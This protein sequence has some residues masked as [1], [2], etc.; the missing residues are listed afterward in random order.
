MTRIWRFSV[1]LLLSLLLSACGG[2]KAP[3][4]TVSSITNTEQQLSL[5][6]AGKPI[7]MTFWA[8][9]C[10]SCL[11][12]IPYLSAM[13][14]EFGER[15]AVIGVAMSYDDPKQ[16]TTFIQQRQIPYMITHDVD[17]SVSKGFGSIYVTPTNLLISP[18]GE[19]V[20]KQVGTPDFSI[21]KQR[22]QAM[23]KQ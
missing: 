1:P 14:A 4:L 10:P 8:T 19:V 5:A 7:L 21:V 3:D 16:L 9:S 22:I 17:Q 12:E 11:E 2:S 13:Q 20:W 15:I 23:L 6:R 18:Q